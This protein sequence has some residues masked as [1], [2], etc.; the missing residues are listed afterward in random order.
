MNSLQDLNSYSSTVLE[1]SDSRKSIVKFDRVYPLT[2]QNQV[3]DIVST[4]TVVD[5]GINI[6]EIVNYSTANVRYRITVQNTGTPALTGSTVSW[7]S[8]PSGVTLSSG[9][10]VYTLSGITRPGIWDL[11]KTITWNLPSNYAS[12]PTWNLKSEIIYYDQALGQDVTVS[13]LS[14]DPRFYFRAQLTSTATVTAKGTYYRA[15]GKANRNFTASV[16]C[17]GRRVARGASLFTSGGTVTCSLTTVIKNLTARTYTYNS[18]NTFWDSDYPS[19][20]SEVLGTYSKVGF[21]LSVSSGYLA[22]EPSFDYTGTG[23][24]Y[25]R[26]SARSYATS[27]TKEYDFL[28]DTNTALRNITYYPAKGQS[29]AATLTFSITKNTSTTIITKTINLSSSG[30]YTGSYYWMYMPDYITNLSYYWYS[31]IA[32][33][34]YCSSKVDAVL[35]GAQGGSGNYPSYGAGGG[36]GVVQLTNVSITAPSG[37][38]ISGQ[39]F[40]LGLRGF[41]H[42]TTPGAAGGDGSSTSA[43]GST[44]GGGQGGQYHAGGTSG[45]PQSNAGGGWSGSTAGSGGG[46]GGVGGGYYY[47]QGPGI[48]TWAGTV[49]EGQNRYIGG[50]GEN[51][52]VFIRATVT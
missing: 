21:T 52:I 50:D 49:G 35:V 10:G 16:T 47:G 31:A 32:I 8:L 41:A 5:P 28:T 6:I 42:T 34:L 40:T 18:P 4:T 37:G 11:V 30:T 43:F 14:Y 9:G 26:E 23:G 15:Q 2:A 38:T 12:C 44:A 20:S 46:A 29:S 19:I 1:V 48:S 24:S 17:L 13:W 39:L 3:F 51:G 33:H 7:T 36:G 22:Y 45:S 27:I 25:I